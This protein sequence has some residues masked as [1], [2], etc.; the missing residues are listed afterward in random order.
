MKELLEVAKM[1]RWR[2]AGYGTFALVIMIWFP[3]WIVL[4]ILAVAVFALMDGAVAGYEC[5]ARAG[6]RFQRRRDLRPFDERS[7]L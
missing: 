6:F 1:L 5:R 2:F 7:E 3:A 4:P